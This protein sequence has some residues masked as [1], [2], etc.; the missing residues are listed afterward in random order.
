VETLEKVLGVEAVKEM[1][2]MQPGDVQ[3]T[4][5]DLTDIKR[6]FNFQPTTSIEEGLGMFVTWYRSYYSQ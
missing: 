5:A 4:H 1:Y 3:S 6:D 2:P